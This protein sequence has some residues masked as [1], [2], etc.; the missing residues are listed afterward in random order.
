[1]FIYLILVS[2]VFISLCGVSIYSTITASFESERAMSFCSF[3]IA[4]AFL[5]FSIYFLTCVG[6]KL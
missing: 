1:M 3:L 6:E 4:F 2:L 5:F